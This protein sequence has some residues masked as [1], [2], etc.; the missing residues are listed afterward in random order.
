[1]N[2]YKLEKIKNSIRYKYI[3]ILFELKKLYI[4][5]R[6]CLCINSI[7][8]KNSIQIIMYFIIIKIFKHNI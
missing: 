8:M 7:K 5:L 3:Y 1:M 2:V 4:D 6:S